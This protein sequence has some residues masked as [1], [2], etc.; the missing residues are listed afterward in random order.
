MKEMFTADSHLDDTDTKEKR[1]QCRAELVQVFQEGLEVH[2]VSVKDDDFENC[3]AFN[4]L[5]HDDAS[6]KLKTC[7]IADYVAPAERT[8]AHI[9]G[10]RFASDAETL[11]WIIWRTKARVR[12]ARDDC[13]GDASA[14]RGRAY[15]TRSR[16]RQLYL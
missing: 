16:S 9:L 3:I 6:Q 1:Y 7:G 14:G 2:A 4:T 11:A 10:G 12:L 13:W 15:K 8:R 5:A